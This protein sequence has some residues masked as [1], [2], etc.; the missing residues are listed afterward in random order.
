MIAI[1]TSQVALNEIRPKLPSGV[2]IGT[3]IQSV[4]GRVAICH[5][6]VDIDIQEIIA[7]GGQI[8]NDMP[9]DWKYLVKVSE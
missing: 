5:N 9:D 8:F 7:N 4:D 1:F 2:T 3:P 6:F